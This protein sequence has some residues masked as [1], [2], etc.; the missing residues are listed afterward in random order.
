MQIVL[1]RLL[2]IEWNSTRIGGPAHKI[3]T[4]ILHKTMPRV[5]MMKRVLGLRRSRNAEGSE[6][7][8]RIED[9]SGGEFRGHK[10][11]GALVV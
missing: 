7:G 8:S 5:V 2:S 9:T 4:K 6:I 3:L 11:L 1:F 10:S